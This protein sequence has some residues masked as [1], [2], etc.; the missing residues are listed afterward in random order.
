MGSSPQGNMGSGNP[1]ELQRGMAPSGA[2]PPSCPAWGS[3][4]RD[5]V[6]SRSQQWLQLLL[7]ASFH[8]W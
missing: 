4:L 3:K 1:K 6:M 8:H 5:V 7:L 2:T